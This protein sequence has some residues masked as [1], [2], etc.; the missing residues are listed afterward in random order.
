ML[1]HKEEKKNLPQHK[2][3]ILCSSPAG[4]QEHPGMNYFALGIAQGFRK[5]PLTYL[6]LLTRVFFAFCLLS[7]CMQDRWAS[8]LG[9][10]Q[11]HT[12]TVPAP[13]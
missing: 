7:P 3:S 13:R 1:K 2:A 12:Q 10:K 11:A 8:Y 9:T 4:T 6:V 5:K